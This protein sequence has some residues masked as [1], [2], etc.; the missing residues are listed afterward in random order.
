MESTILSTKQGDINYHD[1]TWRQCGQYI[2]GENPSFTLF[3]NVMYILCE[4]FSLIPYNDGI[5]LTYGVM[6]RGT[7]YNIMK[8]SLHATCDFGGLLR[9]LLVSFTNKADRYDI[10]HVLLKVPLIQWHPQS[11]AENTCMTISLK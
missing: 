3:I 6:T 8:W 9:L 11:T 7:R 2:R 1:R 4:L 10:S 5:Y